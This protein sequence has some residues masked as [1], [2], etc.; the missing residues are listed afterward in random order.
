VNYYR[1]LID[2]TLDRLL[3]GLPAIS[4]DGAK[5]VGKTATGSRRA[6]TV[7]RL[8]DHRTVEVVQAN[9]GLV[10]S[11]ERPVFIDEWQL[12]PEVWDQVRRSVDDSRGEPGMFLLAG[13]NTPS[14]GARLHSGAGRIIRLTM[15]PLSMV[16]RGREEPT[17]SL[18]GLFRGAV[19]VSGSTRFG[20]TDYLDEILASGFPGIRQ[21]GDAFRGEALDGY[22][23][24]IVEKDLEDLGVRV[25][26]P[27]ALMAW[28][29]AHAAATGTSAEYMKILNAA[30]PG[31]SDKPSRATTETYREHLT[32]LFL[33]DPL[34]PWLPGFTP[35][36][37]LTVS[38][39]HHLVDPSLAARLVGVRREGLL[40]GE[41]DRI[42]GAT[43]SWLGALFE[44][45]VVQSVRVYAEY[46]G[47]TVGHLRTSGGDREIDLIVEDDNRDVVAIEVKLAGTVGDHDVRHLHW[48]KKQIGPRLKDSIVV[49]TGPYAYRRADGIA[50]V[51]F[52]AL[53]P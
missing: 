45:L 48:L 10:S 22:L 39:K 43:G 24:R 42:A 29:R 3:A 44:S 16:E 6:A 23:S 9:P 32:R 12:V 2:D 14:P 41:G 30:T 11:L 19:E 33:L 31:E 34:E 5:A 36:K 13:S 52:I 21:L 51:P 7:L 18:G 37:R 53:G 35:L 17:V 25:R 8:D 40:H 38:P 4:I 28:L 27:A 46:R 49:T 15:R 47:M 50:V 26:R 1:R 20:L